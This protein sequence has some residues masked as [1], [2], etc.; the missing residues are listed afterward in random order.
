M[1]EDANIKLCSFVSDITGVTGRAIL[2]ALIAEA[3]LGITTWSGFG[4][5]ETSRPERWSAHPLTNLKIAWSPSASANARSLESKAGCGAAHRKRGRVHGT[6]CVRAAIGVDTTRV[7]DCEPFRRR[8][9]MG[10]YDIKNADA[11][12]M[13]ALGESR[14]CQTI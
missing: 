2:E 9:S 11:S 3:V 1:L 10:E 7:A 12:Q 14:E 13:A 5:R 6:E 8:D 4:S